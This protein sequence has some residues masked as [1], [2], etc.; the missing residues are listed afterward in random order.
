MTV[1]LLAGCASATSTMLETKDSPSCPTT[2]N[3]KGVP[4]T[5]K[6]A[7]HLRVTITEQQYFEPEPEAVALAKARTAALDADK[8]LAEMR[9]K[10]ESVSK[11]NKDS[12]SSEAVTADGEAQPTSEDEAQPTDEELTRLE[13][14]S[15]RANAEWAAILQNLD[16]VHLR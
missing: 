12:S 8:T 10:K 1:L 7:T 15:I 9:A 13:E 4:M 3:G 16:Q 5:L 2:V 14:A 11:Q 6:V